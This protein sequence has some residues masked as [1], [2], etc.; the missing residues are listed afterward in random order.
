M[1]KQNRA[2]TSVTPAPPV[3][4]VFQCYFQSP[5]DV[6]TREEVDRNIVVG[7]VKVRK[8]NVSSPRKCVKKEESAVAN[9]DVASDAVSCE[10]SS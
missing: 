3:M 10:S 4:L 7:I 8:G 2:G 5:C 1:K 9:H 6:H